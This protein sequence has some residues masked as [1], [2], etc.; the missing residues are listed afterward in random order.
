MSII[1]WNLEPLLTELTT[2]VVLAKLI[3]KYP[4]LDSHCIMSPSFSPGLLVTF[5][6]QKQSR[7]DLCIPSCSQTHFLFMST[8][9]SPEMKKN[10]HLC[11]P[12]HLLP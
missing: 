4:F 8:L 6:P 1:R 2:R 11:S 5:R 7:M 3:A 10:C 9:L 12:G